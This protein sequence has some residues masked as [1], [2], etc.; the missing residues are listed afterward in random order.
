MG[1]LITYQGWVIISLSSVMKHYDEEGMYMKIYK[2]GRPCEG[3]MKNV[4]IGILSSERRRNDSMSVDYHNTSEEDRYGIA[5]ALT[6]SLFK[7]QDES[8]KV[9]AAF[10][11][12]L[13]VGI[14]FIEAYEK[15]TQELDL[16]AKE[17]IP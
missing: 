6:K 14:V 10:K 4:L 7:S 12:M 11:K 17:H 9:Q 13:D 1:N 15:N 2:K 8:S 3:M 5:I 16:S